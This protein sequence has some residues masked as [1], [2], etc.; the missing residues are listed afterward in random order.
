[1]EGQS[2]H[3]KCTKMLQF[4]LA[5]SGA[6]DGGTVPPWCILYGGMV[7]P[8]NCHNPH[9]TSTQLQLNSTELG[10]TPW[11]NPTCFF[12]QKKFRIQIFIFL[13]KVFFIPKFFYPKY[14]LTQN[15]YDPKNFSPKIFL[16]WPKKGFLVKF[17]L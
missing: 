17:F 12:R 11:V 6:T 8:W 15:F 3:L 2:L 4:D 5:S 14:S 1:M 16:S 7:Q 9:S 10:M 13:T